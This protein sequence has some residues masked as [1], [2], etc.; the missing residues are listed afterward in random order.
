MAKSPPGISFK[1]YRAIACGRAPRPGHQ[2]S[3]KLKVTLPKLTSRARSFCTP[4]PEPAVSL[5]GAAAGFLHARPR[6]RSPAL[7]RG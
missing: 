1:R 4:G 5:S 6:A 7:G 3:K 2:R